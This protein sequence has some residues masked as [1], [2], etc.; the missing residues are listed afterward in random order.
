MKCG[1]EQQIF[2]YTSNISRSEPEKGKTTFGFPCGIGLNTYG[3]NMNIFI[4]FR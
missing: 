4:Q 1:R 3:T 2:E